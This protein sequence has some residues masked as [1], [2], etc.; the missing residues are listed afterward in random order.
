MKLNFLRVVSYAII[1]KSSVMKWERTKAL[2]ICL[3]I[4][5]FLKVFHNFLKI[6]ENL[7]Y[8]NKCLL[9]L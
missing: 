2:K 8:K 1:S 3:L 6:Y 4:K 9:D 7:K 5:F